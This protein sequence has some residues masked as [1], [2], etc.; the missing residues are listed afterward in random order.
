[1]K[2][3]HP[4]PPSYT[5]SEI[6]KKNDTCLFTPFIYVFI[7]VT[8]DRDSTSA[9]TFDTHPTRDLVLDMLQNEA[10]LL[11]NEL[12]LD[13]V[14]LTQLVKL[15]AEYVWRAVAADLHTHGL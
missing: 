3:Q 11:W 15:V 1:M 6:I 12:H 2:F 14:K 7:L 4:V 5:T 8:F 10:L 13:V 9:L